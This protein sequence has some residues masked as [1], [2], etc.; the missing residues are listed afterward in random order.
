[1][2]N[3]I[4]SKQIG[5]SSIV[6]R[7]FF[8]RSRSVRTSTDHVSF[9]GTTCVIPGAPPLELLGVIGI[10]GGVVW[11]FLFEK[12]KGIGGESGEVYV[13]ET[14]EAVARDKGTCSSIDLEL[15]RN[16]KT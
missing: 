2:I 1:M 16:N 6:S 11:I 14:E 9:S 8:F 15:C 5:H 7:S 3:K 10:F 12:V 13:L 4:P